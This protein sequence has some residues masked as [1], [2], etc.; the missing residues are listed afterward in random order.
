MYSTEN[1]YTS[2]VI[3]WLLVQWILGSLNSAK[4]SECLLSYYL[5]VSTH[6]C[7]EF[8]EKANF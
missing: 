1:M 6:S 3:L 8:Q 4:I 5:L 7:Y 2:S